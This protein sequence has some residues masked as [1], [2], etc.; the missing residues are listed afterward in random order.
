V[1]ASSAPI[2]ESARN[3]H[4]LLHAAGEFI[5]MPVGK[6]L[7]TDQGELVFG[8][9]RSRGFVHSAQAQPQR[10]VVAHRQ[11]RHQRVLLEDDTAVGAR[12][13]HRPAVEQDL[14]GGRRQKAGDAIQQR[15]LAA[16]RGAERDDE[17]AVLHGQVDGRQRL[18]RAALDGVVERQLADVQRRHA[19][20]LT[21]PSP[22]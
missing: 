3:A 7:Q 5:D 17:V 15:R 6:F 4:A 16:A 22:S 11:P 9:A 2:G 19:R 1:K 8:D 14:A 12:A 21:S 18:Q 13:D 10:D 20:G